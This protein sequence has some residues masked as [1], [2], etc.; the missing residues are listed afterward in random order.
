MRSPVMPLRARRKHWRS[1]REHTRPTQ[2]RSDA[3]PGTRTPNPRIKC[4]PS[5]CFYVLAEA[6]Q[7]LQR[8]C[9][10]G[11]VFATIEE[12]AVDAFVAEYDF[13]RPP[14][15]HRRRLPGRPVPVDDVQCGHSAPVVLVPAG[16]LPFTPNRVPAPRA[17]AD[18]DDR[19]VHHRCRRTTRAVALRSRR[20]VD[21]AGRGLTRIPTESLARLNP[22]HGRPYTAEGVSRRRRAD[23]RARRAC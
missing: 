1:S 4:R 6:H 10:N 15:G 23:R 7:T 14:P 22:G 21:L 3:P 2:V 20:T 19:P 8:E 18:S 11:R 5:R 13:V 9:V 12:A 16:L 17:P